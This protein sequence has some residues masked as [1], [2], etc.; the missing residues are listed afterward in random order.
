MSK[1]IILMTALPPSKGHLHLINF[2]AKYPGVSNVHIVLCTRT[3]EPIP[4]WLRLAALQQHAKEI[5]GVA[6]VTVT[7]YQNDDAPQNPSNTCSLSEFWKYWTTVIY[8]I[9]GND[10]HKDD[11]VFASDMYAR[12]MADALGCKFVPCNVYREIVPVSA[13]EIRKNPYKNFHY[14]APRFQNMMRRTVTFFGPE[15]TGKTTVSKIMARLM[16]A[17]WLP[18]YARE[19][20]EVQT[21]PEVTLERMRDIEL[22]QHTSETVIMESVDKPFIFRDTDLLSTVGY[23]HIMEKSG[24]IKLETEVQR[25]HD[26]WYLTSPDLYIVMND[27]IPFTIDKLR[28]GKD[29]RESD[30][31]FWIKLLQD[32]EQKFHVVRE[33]EVNRQIEEITN[34]I[35]EDFNEGWG[36]TSKFARI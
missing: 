4:G 29:E 9:V 21:S 27:Q 10:I 36:D 28:F 19:Y 5:I 2:A 34:V 13:T 32:N 25:C 18:E 23:Y 8:S 1:G 15:S 12:D 20:L 14:L 16:N 17:H 35:M 3:N 30:N 7:E 26:L 33:T 22:G 24:G 31:T 11:I 6:K